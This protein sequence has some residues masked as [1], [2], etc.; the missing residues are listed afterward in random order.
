MTVGTINYTITT[1]STTNFYTSFNTTN[2]TISSL[3]GLGC[4]I[5]SYNGNPV[6]SD[7]VFDSSGEWLG[8]LVGALLGV[9]AVLIIK[10]LQVYHF[11]M[12]RV[13]YNRAMAVANFNGSNYVIFCL[14]WFSFIHLHFYLFNYMFYGMT[15]PCFGSTKA[16]HSLITFFSDVSTVLFY[17]IV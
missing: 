9:V 4:F 11:D 7:K 14:F 5:D 1:T 8:Y 3:Q 6:Y 13:R 12:I 16:Y 15:E 2:R 10:I 17:V